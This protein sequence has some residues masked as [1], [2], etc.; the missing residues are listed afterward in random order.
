MARKWHKLVGS[1]QRPLSETFATPQQRSSRHYALPPPLSCPPN[2]R[3]SSDTVKTAMK[4]P[5]ASKL[6]A[7]RFYGVVDFMGASVRVLEMHYAHLV[8]DAEEAAR[9][10]LDARA[11]AV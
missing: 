1:S 6:R 8:P 3:L 10:K 2:L 5:R 11:T 7:V 4:R 9:A